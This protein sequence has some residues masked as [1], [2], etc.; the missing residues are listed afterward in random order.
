MEG[1]VERKD[2][3]SGKCLRNEPEGLDITLKNK[4]VEQ[5]FKQARCWNFCKKLQGGH[6]QVTKEFALNFAG[7]NSK[8][9]MLE[10]PVSPD[11]IAIVTEIPRGQENWFKNFKF[12]MNPCKEFL[13]QQFINSDLSKSVPR[14]YVKESYAQLLTCIHKYLTDEGR[15][16]KVYSYHFKLLLHFTG[17]TSI[18]LP[19]Y[20]FRS[21]SKMCDKVQLRKEAYEASLFHHG[22]VKLMVLHELQKIGRDWDTFIFMS[23][24]QSKTRLS[25]LVAKEPSTT[26][27]PQ[28]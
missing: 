14:S 21:L 16:N 13:K 4:E 10:L 11:M 20:L 8:V 5:A 24:F 28:A 27:S 3:R 17:K 25:P 15:Y 9:G 6:A 12:D 2:H 1:S 22:L 18:D 23:G 19:F 26:T 7:L